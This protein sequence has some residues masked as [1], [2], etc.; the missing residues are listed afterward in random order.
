MLMQQFLRTPGK[1]LPFGKRRAKNT[2]VRVLREHAV[3]FEG[4]RGGESLFKIRSE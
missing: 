3:Y 1:G 2:C 4:G